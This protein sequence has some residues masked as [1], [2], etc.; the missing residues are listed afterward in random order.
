MT[1]KE[2]RD[3]YRLNI[4]S[5][6]SLVSRARVKPPVQSVAFTALG[7]SSLQFGEEDLA[8]NDR[9]ICGDVGRGKS[10]R[11]FIG[12]RRIPVCFDEFG[13]LMCH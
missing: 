4:W 12:V 10:L 13:G 11:R 7:C 6:T 8:V 1:I 9:Q 2:A 3:T 5:L